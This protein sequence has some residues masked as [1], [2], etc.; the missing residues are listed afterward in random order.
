MKLSFLFR[1]INI[2]HIL[3]LVANHGKLPDNENLLQ[4]YK[5]NVYLVDLQ[6]TFEYIH[7]NYDY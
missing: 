3:G 4:L 2:F 1:E 7:T 6:Q 5:L